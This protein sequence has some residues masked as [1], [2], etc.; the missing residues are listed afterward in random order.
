MA[1]WTNCGPLVPAVWENEKNTSTVWHQIMAK[2]QPR[3]RKGTKYL[4]TL[5]CWGIWKE[6]NSRIF[7]DKLSPKT[8]IIACIQV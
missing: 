1:T 6:R 4:F 3:H 8:A 2:A 5:V 7:K